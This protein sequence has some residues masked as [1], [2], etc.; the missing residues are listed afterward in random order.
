MPTLRFTA[1]TRARYED[2]AVFAL[3]LS[4][5]LVFIWFGVLKIFGFNPVFDLIAVVTPALASGAGLAALGVFETAIG[6]ALALNR[7]RFII[8]TLLVLHLL[9]TFIVFVTGFD[10]VFAPYFPVLSL[11]GEFV[12]KNAVLVAA[13]LTVLLHEPR[14]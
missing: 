1:T 11:D 9:G 10:I 7:A 14:K 12:V 5:A 3:R 13:G 6:L 8:H 2:L 4:L